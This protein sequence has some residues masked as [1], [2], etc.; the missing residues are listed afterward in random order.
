MQDYA[1]RP[2]LQWVDPDGLP[3]PGLTDPWPRNCDDDHS[4]PRHDSP[5][6]N[7]AP[8]RQPKFGV[9]CA[10]TPAASPHRRP[11]LGRC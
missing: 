5:Q 4:R 11:D 3:E 7:H 6:Y 9:A 2:F 1:V 8:A 10:A